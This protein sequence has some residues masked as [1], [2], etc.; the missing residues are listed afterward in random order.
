MS[1]GEWVIS[2]L[3]NQNQNCLARTNRRRVKRGGGGA[4]STVRLKDQI[5]KQVEA[6]NAVYELMATG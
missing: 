2:G 3:A 6:E 1:K 4:R 5:R